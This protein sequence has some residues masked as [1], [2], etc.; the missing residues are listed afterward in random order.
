MIDPSITRFIAYLDQH[1]AG[2][3]RT[4]FTTAE[5]HPDTSAA[6]AFAER[7]REQFADHLGE[8]IDVEQRVNVVRVTSIAQ[9][10]HA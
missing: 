9:A 3:D 4:E 10:V 7:M 1:C 5:G 8:L 2:V 6:R